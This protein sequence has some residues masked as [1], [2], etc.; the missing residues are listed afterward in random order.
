ML[1]HSLTDGEDRFS[2]C[3][4]MAEEEVVVMLFNGM[5][6]VDD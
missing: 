3:E 5:M 1:P 2:S 4:E 6:G